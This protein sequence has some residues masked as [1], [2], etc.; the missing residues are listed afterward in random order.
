MRNICF[1]DGAPPN[2]LLSSLSVKPIPFLSPGSTGRPVVV[3]AHISC[4]LHLAPPSS[5][6]F[7][8]GS[9][10]LE[11]NEAIHVP[12]CFES[13]GGEM[14]PCLHQF[15]ERL[16]WPNPLVHPRSGL[17]ETFVNPGD[18][19]YI[20]FQHRLLSNSSNS[21]PLTREVSELSVRQINEC[22]VLP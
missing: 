6:D 8:P 3:C 17:G 2:R 12:P 9:T 5:L 21:L 11:I 1:E 10:P 13:T 22:D 18:L 4:S 19:A 14:F 20:A 16:G 15:D 7:H